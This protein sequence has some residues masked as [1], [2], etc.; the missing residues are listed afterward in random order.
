MCLLPLRKA[1]SDYSYME[2]LATSVPTIIEDIPIFDI[3]ELSKDIYQGN[4]RDC[5]QR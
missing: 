2:T 4:L 3:Q 5:R 1:D